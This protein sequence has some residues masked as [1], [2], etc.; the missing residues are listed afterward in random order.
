[1]RGSLGAPLRISTTEQGAVNCPYGAAFSP[2]SAHVAIIGS[3]S[4]CAP[5][6]TTL[7]PHIAAIYDTRS[8]VMT[9]Y[10]RLEK[11]LGIRT[12]VSLSQQPIQAIH[13]FSLGWS[14]D[15]SRIAIVFTAFDS[16]ETQTPDTERDTGLIVLDAEHG[17]ARVIYGDSGYFTLPGTNG[18]GFPSGTLRRAPPCLHTCL[19]RAWRTHGINKAC[20]TPS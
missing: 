14:P 11:L 13:Y 1:M 7:T 2:D 17:T 18:S 3:Q 5:T 15:G 4:T 10:V 9:L 6:T 16:A 8:G 20:P 19:I 12:D